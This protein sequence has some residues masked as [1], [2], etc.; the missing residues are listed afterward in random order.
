MNFNEGSS[1]RSS[2][3]LQYPGYL[4]DLSGVSPVFNA[5]F[6]QK[7]TEKAHGIFSPAERHLPVQ[8][9]LTACMPKSNGQ[10]LHKFCKNH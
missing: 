8:G 10:N 3:F 5:G 2:L 9:T 1:W 7:Y 6:P 4:S